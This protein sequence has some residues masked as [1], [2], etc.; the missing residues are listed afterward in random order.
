[1]K[2]SPLEIIFRQFFDP[3]TENNNVEAMKKW[4]DRKRYEKQN[5]SIKTR[6]SK[7]LIKK[8]RAILNL[9]SGND[10]VEM[11]KDVFT[12]KEIAEIHAGIKI[13][14]FCGNKNERY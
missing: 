7:L 10:I 3:I 8:I 5:V 11:M 6:K 1:M 9:I 4:S 2:H 13:K 14:E 12:S